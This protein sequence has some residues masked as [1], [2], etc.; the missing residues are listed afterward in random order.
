M[1]EQLK[2][3]AVKLL[4]RKRR[5]V[6]S[7]TLDAWRYQQAHLKD[8]VFDQPLISCMHLSFKVILCSIVFLA[9]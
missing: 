4:I 6:P 9:K 1:K 2:D 8:Q 7:S 3:Q 5:K